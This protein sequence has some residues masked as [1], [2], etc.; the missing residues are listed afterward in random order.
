MAPAHAKDIRQFSTENHWQ[1]PQSNASGGIGNASEDFVDQFFADP[2][3]AAD[4]KKK[5]QLQWA[6]LHVS[7]SND[8]VTTTQDVIKFASDNTSESGSQVVKA[9]DTFQKVFGKRLTGGTNVTLLASQTGAFSLVPYVSAFVD[10]D[11]NVPS[12]PQAELL[13]EAYAG[14]GLGYA[15]KIKNQFSLGANLRPG[16][17]TYAHVT[18]DLSAVGGFATENS[19]TDSTS[20]TGFTQK[21]GTA[22]YIPVDL[23]GAYQ[24]NPKWRTHV[25]FRNF[26][27][28][29]AI[30]VLSGSKPPVYPMRIQLGTSWRPWEKGGHQ[31]NLYAELQDLMGLSQKSAVWYRLQAAGQ[32]L[33][34]LSFRTQTSFGLYGGLRSGYPSYGAFLDLVLLKIEAAAYTR[35]LGHSIGQRPEKCYS[36]RA[37]SQLTF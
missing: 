7:Y 13:G 27:G 31:T 3:L 30:S 25:T 26:A 34:R 11:I 14:V 28:A 29:P 33:Y 6:S 32:Y 1:S 35:E 2:S 22:F 19:T 20:G 16:V 9:L 18:G 8:L 10:G 37:F 4:E 12:W 23:A 17:R 36:L 5:F 15:K 24:W 21:L